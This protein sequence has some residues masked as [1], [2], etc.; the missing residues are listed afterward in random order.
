MLR[1][2]L[3]HQKTSFGTLCFDSKI[4][5]HA[6]PRELL[7]GLPDASSMTPLEWSQAAHLVPQAP[8]LLAP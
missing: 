8:Q 7:L 5:F 2:C 1:A 3:I 4:A 6:V